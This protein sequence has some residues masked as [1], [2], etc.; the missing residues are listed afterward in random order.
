M[1]KMDSI[2]YG[3]NYQLGEIKNIQNQLEKDTLSFDK[4]NYFGATSKFTNIV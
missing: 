3:I 2:L 1:V 4:I